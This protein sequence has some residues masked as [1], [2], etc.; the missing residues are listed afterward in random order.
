[1][2]INRHHPRQFREVIG[3]PVGPDPGERAPAHLSVLATRP[4]ETLSRE[5]TAERAD[6]AVALAHLEWLRPYLSEQTYNHVKTAL[7]EGGQNSELSDSAS[8]GP[9]SGP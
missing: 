2:P 7:S 4:I 3:G 6:R 5:A 9:R 1:M 8:E